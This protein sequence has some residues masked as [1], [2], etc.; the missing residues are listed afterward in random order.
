MDTRVDPE[1]ERIAGEKLRRIKLFGREII[2]PQ[3]RLLRV[4]IGVVL[5]ILGCF[6]FLPIL[7]FWMIPLGLLVL[8][9]EFAAIRRWRRRFVVQWSRR[10]GRWLLRTGRMIRIP[11]A[12]VE[13]MECGKSASDDCAVDI[14]STGPNQMASGGAFSCRHAPERRPKLKAVT[15]TC[16][17]P[18]PHKA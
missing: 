12:A 5:V 7:G 17:K 2:L 13:E 15:D 11:A 6:G 16:A 10:E 4:T 8:S 14:A 9:Y 3:S 1:L 18:R